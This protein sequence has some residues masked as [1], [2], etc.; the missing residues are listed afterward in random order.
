MDGSI[1]WIGLYL[2]PFTPYVKDIMVDNVNRLIF[3]IGLYI[4]PSVKYVVDRS[5]YLLPFA[6]SV[7]EYCG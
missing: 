7:K 6:P 1:L 4:T 2:L 5:I 3:G